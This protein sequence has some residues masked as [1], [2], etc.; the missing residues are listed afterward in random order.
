MKLQIKNNKT[1]SELQKEFQKEFPYLKLEFFKKSHGTDEASAKKDI[2]DSNLTIGEI[3]KKEGTLSIESTQKVGEIEQQFRKNFSLF[4]QIFRKSG[5]VWLE[6][7]KTDDWTIEEQIV[8][9]KESEQH[10]TYSMHN[11]A[12]ERQ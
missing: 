1:L 12:D 11:F 7:S 2:L 9:A 10:Y 3:S 4:V 6:T 5:N 8:A